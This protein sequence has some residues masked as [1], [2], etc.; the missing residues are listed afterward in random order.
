MRPTLHIVTLAAALIA[1]GAQAQPFGGGRAMQAI[2]TNGDGAIQRSEIEA[3][4]A[5]R[6][7]RL[8]ANGDGM[9][10][11]A[12]FN[13]SLDRMFAAVDSNGDNAISRAEMAAKTSEMRA[14]VGMG[15]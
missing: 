3:V 12:E 2:D 13:G 11:P 14:L 1:T 9:V 10:T 7:Q 4:N 15:N 6:F 8:D 5:M